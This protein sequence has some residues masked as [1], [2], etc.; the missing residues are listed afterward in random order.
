MR[1]SE[2]KNKLKRIS[3]CKKDKK[4]KD[5]MKLIKRS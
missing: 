5:N 3:Y 4:N 2:E 1:K